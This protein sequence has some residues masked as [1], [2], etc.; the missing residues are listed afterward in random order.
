MGSKDLSMVS[1]ALTLV[2][3]LIPLLFNYFLGLGIGKKSLIAVLRMCVQLFLIGYFLGYIFDLNNS[4]LNFLW[5]FVMIIVSTISI[6]NSCS[7]KFKVFLWPILISVAL[8]VILMCLYF[9]RFIV[10]LDN[11]FDAKYLIAIGGMILGNML[12]GN[13]VGLN[14]FFN[15]VR[16]ME[17]K[18]LAVLALGADRKEA[19]LPH[20][21]ESIL[22]AVNPT[23]AS[24][25]TIG[26]VSLPGMMTGQILGGASPVVAVKY[27]M[28]IMIAIFITRIL[29]I[30]IALYLTQQTAF[31]AYDV[32]RKE[33]FKDK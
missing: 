10:R 29:S 30:Y 4:W 15:N 5:L 27:Q 22:A 23:I 9:N 2:L 12:S 25:A 11:I 8:P 7:L 13:I 18:Y 24:T 20:V 28:A 19:L 1:L 16:K 6:V 17:K 33:I 31:D 26:L 14:H 32:L 3:L 21:R